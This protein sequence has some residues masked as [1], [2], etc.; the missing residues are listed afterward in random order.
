LLADRVIA[1]DVQGAQAM[2][3]A[4]LRSTMDFVYPSGSES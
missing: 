3:S 4:H 2:L 1:R